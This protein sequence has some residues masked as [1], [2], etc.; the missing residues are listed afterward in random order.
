M[1]A[2]FNSM[3]HYIKSMTGVFDSLTAVFNSMT[4]YIDSMTGVFDSMTHWV[5]AMTDENIFKE[6]LQIR[7]NMANW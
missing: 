7:R 1:K 5:D 4:H 2:V 3:T 6:V